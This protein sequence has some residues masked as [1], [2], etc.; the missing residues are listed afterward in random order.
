MFVNARLTMISPLNFKPNAH[1]KSASYVSKTPQCHVSLDFLVAHCTQCILLPC[2]KIIPLPITY[3]I[4][5]QLSWQE[6]LLTSESLKMTLAYTW[7]LVKWSEVAQPCPTLCDPRDCSLQGST[8]HGIF[9]ARVLEWVAITFSR[10]SSWPRDR[11]QV[12]CIAGRHFYC[13]RHQGRLKQWI[14]I[15]L[16]YK[17]AYCCHCFPSEWLSP[18]FTK[19]LKS[20]SR[21]SFFLMLYF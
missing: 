9:Q 16:L 3:F 13:L 19:L 7:H 12:S 14:A 6:I 20:E 4:L 8:V 5:L 11:T 21:L 1:L 10:G 17:P 15:I 18:V 2:W